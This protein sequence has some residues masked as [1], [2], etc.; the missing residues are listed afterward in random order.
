[1]FL[2]GIPIRTWL[3]S[4]ITINPGR[5]PAELKETPQHCGYAILPGKLCL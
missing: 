4:F 2:I 3:R 1:M 5:I